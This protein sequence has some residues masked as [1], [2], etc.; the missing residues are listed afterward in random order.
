MVIW[1]WILVIGYVISDTQ[2]M[3]RM[4]FMTKALRTAGRANRK[5]HERYPRQRSQPRIRPQVQRNTRQTGTELLLQN[6]TYLLTS[7]NAIL[8]ILFAIVFALTA[9]A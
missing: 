3:L 5:P 6:H 9:F 1:Y 2:V 8:P 4:Y 7:T